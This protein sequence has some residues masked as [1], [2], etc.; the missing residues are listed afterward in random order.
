MM[1][2]SY[3][4]GHV[5]ILQLLLRLSNIDVDQP[6]LECT[7]LHSAASRGNLHAA[8]LLVVY[9]ANRLAEDRFGITPVTVAANNNNPVLARWLTKV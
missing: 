9:G 5:D 7:P 6:S 1:L 3:S 2:S 4:T 8:Q